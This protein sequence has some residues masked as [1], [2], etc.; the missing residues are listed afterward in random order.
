MFSQG[1]L[2][3]QNKII[4]SCGLHGKSSLR[5]V[6]L[7]SG[8]ILKQIKIDR[9]YF[10]EGIALHNGVI[11]MVT[12]K[13]RMLLM[14]DYESL[15]LLGRKRFSSHSGEGWGLTTDGN[16]LILSD[17]SD[18]ITFFSFPLVTDKMEELEKIKTIVVRDQHN[19]A[20]IRNLNELEYVDGFIYS[21]IWYMDIILKIDANSG[22]V[23]NKYNMANIYPRKTR[24]P[25]ADCLNGIAFN[26]TD[27][28]FLVTGKLW[29]KYYTVNLSSSIN[30]LEL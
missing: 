3:H 10:A 11:Y 22:L 13:N 29:H 23:A 9:K 8:K 27:G 4:E 7:P 19:G 28:S 20:I 1:L 26:S 6:S 16:H 14:F 18:R 15:K 2:I 5:I 17:G 25:T 12:Y 24:P 30:G 21:N